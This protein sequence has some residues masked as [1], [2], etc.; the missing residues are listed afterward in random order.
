MQ[1]DLSLLGEGDRLDIAFGEVPH[2]YL[3][4][5]SPDAP[6]RLEFDVPQHEIGVVDDS[7][8]LRVTGCGE[9]DFNV[10]LDELQRSWRSVFDSVWPQEVDGLQR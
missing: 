9:D 5:L 2:R 6:Q 8:S 1:L 4:E 10:S 7:G 3:L